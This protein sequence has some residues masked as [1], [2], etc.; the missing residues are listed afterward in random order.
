M[1]CLAIEQFSS[2]LYFLYTLSHWDHVFPFSKK[3]IVN[4]WSMA[5]SHRT[6][7]GC[8]I[9]HSMAKL[10]FLMLNFAGITFFLMNVYCCSEMHVFTAYIYILFNAAQSWQTADGNGIED[11]IHVH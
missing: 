2:K 8:L 6:I 10:H 11:V 4:K 9:N 1:S 7:T 3:A 5:Q